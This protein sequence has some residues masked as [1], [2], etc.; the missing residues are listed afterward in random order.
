MNYPKYSH[1]LIKVIQNPL[2]STKFQELPETP[3]LLAMRPIKEQEGI[4]YIIASHIYV[5]M[6]GIKELYGES[7]YSMEFGDCL[8]DS[9]QHKLVIAELMHQHLGCQAGFIYA[10]SEEKILLP[11]LS[12]QEILQSPSL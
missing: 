7:H 9:E 10:E 12:M 6:D 5:D 2:K 11:T 4:T 1:K 3:R 8:S